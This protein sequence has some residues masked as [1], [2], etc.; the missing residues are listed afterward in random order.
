MR[1]SQRNR[2]ADTQRSAARGLVLASLALVAGI[3]LAADKGK[4]PRT[5][6]DLEGR[7]VEVR[8]EQ[9]VQADAAQAMRSYRQFLE[10]HKAD[11]ARRAEAMRRLADLNLE[12]SEIESSERALGGGSNMQPVQ[13]AEA[14]K[15]Y[16]LLLETY[17]EYERNDG[18]LYQLA[19]AYE[20][21]NQ[22]RQA[23]RTLDQL[24]TRFPQS[25]LVDEAQFR[26][27]EILFSDKRYADA[28]RAYAEVTRRG[29]A[30]TFYE[31]SLYKRGWSLFKQAR[32]EESLEVFALLMDRKLLDPA[33]RAVVVDVA[34]LSRP[35]RELID[36]TFRVTSI[37]FS[38]LDG[39]QSVDEFIAR[40]NVPAYAH[41]VYSALGDLYL[42]KE[43]FQD[44][45]ETYEA[46]V[47]R[48][49]LAVQAPL[50]QVRAIEAYRKGG[51]TSLVLEG[52]E[53]FVER[54][55][56][57]APFWKG[58]DPRQHPQVVAEIRTSVKELARHY[59]STA[60]KDKD[61]SRKE[62]GYAQA[63]RWYRSYLQW[64]PQEAEAAETNFLLAE[65]LFESRQFREATAEYERTS[66]S[67]PPHA[68][69]AES[70]YAALLSYEQHE[71]ALAGAEK[72]AWHQQFVEAGLKFA[73][74]YPNHEEV[75]AVLTRSAR[76][77]FE[78]K[79]LDRAVY[80]AQRVLALSPPVN[81]AQRRTALTVI[82]HSRFDQ[83][84]YAD[85]EKAYLALRAAIPADDKEQAAITE[86]LAA[87]VYRQAEEKQAA[88]NATGAVDD[89][90]R[91]ARVAP[92]STIRRNAEYDAAVALINLKSWPRAI[93]VLEGFRRNHPKDTLVPEATRS[94]AVAYIETKQHGK[95]AVELERIADGTDDPVEFRREAL[96]RAADLYAKAGDTAGS[97]RGYEKFITRF[98]APLDPAI[99]ARQKLA[100][101]AEQA[102]DTETRDRWLRDIIE[103]DRKAGP[104]RTVRSKYLAAKAT[105][106]FAQPAGQEFAAIRLTAPLKKTLAAKRKA[107]EK[108]LEAYGRAAEYGVAEV[109]TAATYSMA[110][111]YR[112]LARDLLE[113]ERP[114]S[115][116]AADELEQYTILLEEQAFPFEEKAIE[117]HEANA[118]RTR[119]AVYDEWVRRSF[120]VL[121]KLKPARYAK[122]EIGADYTREMR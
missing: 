16:N 2:P 102:R 50:L 96:W 48:D 93:E 40:R 30:S 35:D 80:T 23:L 34:K 110:E 17:P 19:R 77:L 51:F 97:R 55:G 117:I 118:A 4:T 105:L 104:A 109:T 78:L 27:G 119:D 39:A 45:A 71:K 101:M 86:K 90:L 6:K 25:R 63:A 1:A 26:R 58:R 106:H 33:S 5:I 94:L 88:G 99:D 69:S 38:Y 91:V 72:A 11:P 44:A 98:P 42:D 36:D 100:D 24:V 49:P 59:H 75:P 115:L 120:E 122:A 113:S 70:G 64:F 85:A 60:Q 22:G 66:Y 84:R 79:D 62:T 65:A 82:A 53:N 95:A 52:K 87:S 112:V 57:G 81:P 10:L 18:V 108:A 92:D 3:A 121:A 21:N 68:K 43:R 114:K 111:L 37:T 8:V 41:L 107:M 67:Y 56:F 89:F 7:Q 83:Q 76:E 20:S 61:K 54:Y 116:K 32:N 31:Q 28:E 15:L 47:K 29:E 74:A 12:A 103:T 13:A 9:K 73:A 14:V 46:Y